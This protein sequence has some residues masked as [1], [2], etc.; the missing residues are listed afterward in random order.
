MNAR[1]AQPAVPAHIRAR[2]LP[3]G[4]GRTVQLLEAIL[5]V[6]RAARHTSERVKVGCEHGPYGSLRVCLVTPVG[7]GVLYLVPLPHL[8]GGPVA[9]HGLEGATGRCQR[10]ELD[11]AALVAVQDAAREAEGRYSYQ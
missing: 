10:G 7:E 8:P 4:D 9:V 2:M 5:M 11:A 1:V 3:K 6:T